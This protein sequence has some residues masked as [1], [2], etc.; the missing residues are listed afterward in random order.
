MSIKSDLLGK[1]KALSLERPFGLDFSN[2]NVEAI[3]S[4]AK[5]SERM[6]SRINRFGKIFQQLEGLK[7]F[8]A[9]YL[10]SNNSMLQ[11]FR[12]AIVYNELIQIQVFV[13]FFNSIKSDFDYNTEIGKLTKI[14]TNQRMN[15]IRNSIAHFDWE[16]SNENIEFRDNN[17]SRNIQYREVSVLSSLF[18][19]IGI[20]L[21]T[22]INQLNDA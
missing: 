13:E 17:F 5:K 22:D 1:H 11:S 12:D 19:M 20:F 4:E 6:Q 14:F 21:S 16:I 8:N 15:K 3:F 2:I 10:S 18:S 7:Q 9:P